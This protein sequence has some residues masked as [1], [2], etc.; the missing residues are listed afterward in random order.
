MHGDSKK[1]IAAAV[2][3]VVLIVLVNIAWW[4]FYHRSAAMLDDQLSRRLA[5]VAG[6]TASFI[7]PELLEALTDGD[8]EAYSRVSGVLDNIRAEASLAELFVLD[9]DLAYLAT[10]AIEA[11]SAYF[12]AALNGQY[13]D[14]FFFSMHR[15]PIATPSYQSGDIYLKSAFA[16]LYDRDGFVAAVVGVEADVDYFDALADLRTNLY[17]ATAL[18]LLIGLVL[19]SLFLLVQR[20]LNRMQQ[21]LFINETQS[22][23]GR[24][25]AVVSHEIKNPLMIIR[26][27]AERLQ[28]KVPTDESRF[29]VEEVDRLDEIVTGYLDFAG[30]GSGASLVGRE[31]PE[32]IDMAELIATI[33]LHFEQKYADEDIRWIDTDASEQVRFGGY[34]R[35]LRQ[36]LL[37]LLIN[38]AN[39][40]R[41]AGRPISVGIAAR[42]T[43]DTIEITVSDRGTG[44]S[45]R[46][47]RR[48][49][50]PF[51]T[52]GRTGSGLG[53]YL[54]KKIVED[55]GGK[56]SIS[57]IEGKQTNVSITLPN[58]RKK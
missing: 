15:A 23:L 42:P 11:D 3:T 12:L 5:T 58:L 6:T 24:M 46:D 28:K 51:Y 44:I 16:P 30:R 38:G 53:L 19:G 55:M 37:N 33:C 52:T 17:S 50:E 27:S 22:Y 1:L 10:T 47:I 36:V 9:P 18:S 21:Q 43:G 40:C 13:I 57:S 34:R 56:I 29:I 25:V 31:I 49:F 20:R 48:I 41:S 14:S 8:F 2:F 39:A 7:D 45:A 54:S 35:S 32:E 4:L 26:G